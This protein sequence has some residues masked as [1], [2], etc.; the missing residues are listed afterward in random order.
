MGPLAGRAAFAALVLLGGACAARADDKATLVRGVTGGNN[1]IVEVQAGGLALREGEVGGA[2]GTV[3]LASGKRRF[4]YFVVLKHGLNGETGTSTSEKSRVTRTTGESTQ[5]VGVG[6]SKLTIAYR[7][8]LDGRKALGKETLTVNGKAVDAA[9][10]RVLV[11]DM[12]A[13]PPT[14]GQL[15]VELP[16]EVPDASEPKA[17]A[18]LVKRTLAELAKK[19]KPLRA[20]I[21]PAGR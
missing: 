3:Q 20:I 10:G 12:T 1:G 18:A 13:R 4:S 2:F 6:D 16:A 15:K 21:Q 5:V 17:A 7:V 9:K 19:N 11:V 8:Q 14:W